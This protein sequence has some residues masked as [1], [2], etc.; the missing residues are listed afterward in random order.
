M[1]VSITKIED[2]I[3][4]AYEFGAT[5]VAIIPAKKIVVD[6]NLAERCKEPR[7]ENYGLSKSCPP[8][9]S[10]PTVFKNL[11]QTFQQA[12]FFKIDVPSEILYSGQRR[13][14]FELLHQV[15]SGIEK[16]AIKI[17]YLNAQGYAG[18]SC[19]KIFCHN[20]PDCNVISRNGECRNPQYARPSMSGFGINVSKLFEAAGW[21]MSTINHGTDTM[22][23]KMTFVCGLVLIL[24]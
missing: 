18:G 1:T 7:C 4:K 20:H 17:G 9:V 24:M 8:Y 3:Q 10:G 11:L 13:E 6:Y 22:K 5:E 2:I 14:I 23:T 19:K 12:I 16:E 15:A 21:T